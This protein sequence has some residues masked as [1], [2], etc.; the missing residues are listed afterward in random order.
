MR[1]SVFIVMLAGL[2]TGIVGI[3]S[4]VAAGLPGMDQ[5]VWVHYFNPRFG[6]SADV[7]Q[8]GFIAQPP[9]ANGDGQGWMA[10]FGTEIAVYGAYWDVLDPDFVSHRATR[11]GYLV[12]EGARITYE[13]ARSNWFVFSG[14]LADGRIFYDKTLIIPGCGVS[15]NIHIVYSRM[16]RDPMDDITTHVAKSLTLAASACDD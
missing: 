13:P 10:P 12:E 6:V 11:R 5:Q 2:I 3:A 9:P 8:I 16:L 15:A 4:A 1:R 14:Y 7:P